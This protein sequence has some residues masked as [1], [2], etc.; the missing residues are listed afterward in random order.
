MQP[1]LSVRFL[2]VAEGPSDLGLREHL[3]GLLISVGVGT[4]SGVAPDVRSLPH[5]VGH[6]VASK[7]RVGLELEPMVDL[8][9]IHRDSDQSDA[10]RRRSEIQDAVR[11][12]GDTRV[13]V[14]VVPVQETEAW[15]L[16]DEAA[17]RRV[18]GNPSGRNPLSL[19]RPASLEQVGRPKELLQAA[20]RDA[21]EASG[22]RLKKVVARFEAQ[23]RRLLE[24][25]TPG[26][27]LEEVPAWRRLRDDTREAVEKLRSR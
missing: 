14:P 2:L 23:R 7:L 6:D 25:L 27:A 24:E 4:A 21:S 19:P 18:A 17:I 12:V 9:F 3:E 5:R 8:V 22:H 20:I 10:S 16:L 13:W 15:L 1:E 11:A 26:G